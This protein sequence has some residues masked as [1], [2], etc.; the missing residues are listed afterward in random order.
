MNTHTKLRAITF[1]FCCGLIRIATPMGGGFVIEPK[2][3][4]ATLQLDIASNSVRNKLLGDALGGL[5][6]TE[7]NKN[8]E[9]RDAL[10]NRTVKDF[11]GKDL[12]GC[13][14]SNLEVQGVDFS[15]CDLSK[16]D[17]SGSKFSNCYF[18]YAKLE[19]VILDNASFAYT[20]FLNAIIKPVHAYNCFFATSKFVRTAFN[21]ANFACEKTVDGKGVAFSMCII[22]EADF[23][24]AHCTGT[25]FDQ[26]VLSDVLFRETI[27]DEARFYN[28]GKL[29]PKIIFDKTSCKNTYFLNYRFREGLFN[30]VNFQKAIFEGGVFEKCGV[31]THCNFDFA[32]LDGVE[33]LNT[34]FEDCSCQ[35]TWFGKIKWSY[36]P[37]IAKNVNF[38]WAN[39]QGCVLNG[40]EINKEATQRTSGLELFDKKKFLFIKK[41]SRTSFPYSQANS[42][43]DNCDFKGAR[44]SGDEIN[45]IVFKDSQNIQEID[46]LGT[47]FSFSSI[48]NNENFTKLKFLIDKG[49][50]VQGKSNPQY[51]YIWGA[52]P[53]ERSKILNALACGGVVALG[54]AG[55]IL[56]SGVSG[57]SSAAAH[58]YVENLFKE[59]KKALE[60]KEAQQETA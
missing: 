50:R 36:A 30:Q 8:F 33:L 29:T 20:D 34:S 51:S 18:N 19:D 3:Q 11:S 53:V 2:D 17:F 21:N 52:P 12:S 44:F 6:K 43:F 46:P 24:H 41:Y 5:T 59:Q 10:V 4:N 49:A 42:L 22:S 31:I 7:N 58:C 15:H 40:C 32:R 9:I 23:S 26:C 45:N 54:L 27:L 25:F 28:D 57:A 47:S 16:V 1:V 60:K 39:F 13:D 14:L 56:T 48:L 38:N 35:L 37:L 55:T